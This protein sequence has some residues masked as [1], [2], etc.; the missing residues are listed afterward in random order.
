MFLRCV[1]LFSVITLVLL[2]MFSAQAGS[3]LIPN[4]SFEVPTIDP[5]EN[6]FLAIAFA[7]AWTEDDI[8]PE[9][10]SRNTGIFRNTP[11]DSNDHLINP[12]GDQLAF[13]GG[14]QGNA[15]WQYLPETYQEGKSYRLTVGVCVSMRIPP[16]QGT[17]LTLAFHYLYGSAMPVDIAAIQ[18]P[19][20]PSTSRTLEDFSVTL[21]TV[22]AG[23]PWLG[24]NIGIAIRGTGMAGGFWDLDNVRLMELPLVPD[25]TGNS[26][27][28]L[29]DFV[30]LASEWLSCSQTQT[31]LTGEGCVNLEDL[32]ILSENW[33]SNV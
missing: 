27:V 5:N 9:N 19:A 4:H 31:D 12:D 18:V 21:P 23:D 20:P 32:I 30:K 14:Y 16:P 10:L 24:K 1:K 11:A 17:S 26:F 33:L 2:L 28:N 13:L 3:I 7:P 22:Q 15:L 8:D 29:E 6:P 25:F